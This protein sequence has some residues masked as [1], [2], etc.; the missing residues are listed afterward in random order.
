M[1]PVEG[2]LALQPEVPELSMA[3]VLSTGAPRA[4]PAAGDSEA[5]VAVM[6]V[7]RL[8][9]LPREGCAWSVWMRRKGRARRTAR[10]GLVVL[11]EAHGAS[12]PRAPPHRGGQ[13][14][15]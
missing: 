11:P 6:E 9:A 15:P 12:S 14:L 7:G 1:L 3:P 8:V 5:E 2:A 13:G 10:R 4:H